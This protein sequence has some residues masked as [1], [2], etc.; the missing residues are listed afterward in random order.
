MAHAGCGVL[1]AKNLL[2]ALAACGAMCIREQPGDLCKPK[3][4]FLK[5]N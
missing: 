4:V 2:K 1:S 3:G 5:I